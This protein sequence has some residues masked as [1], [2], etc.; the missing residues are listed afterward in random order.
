MKREDK[1]TCSNIYFSSGAYQQVVMDLVNNV[2]ENDTIKINDE[3]VSC[4]KNE[5]RFDKAKNN[6]ENLMLFDLNDDELQVTFSVHFYHTKQKIT[7]QGTRF[8][9][10]ADRFLH[11]LLESQ[12][13]E[14]EDEIKKA[15]TILQFASKN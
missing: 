8:I 4:K 9:K 11:P 14:K 3:S 6:V 13:K 7:V 10:F 12:I 1:S 2:K 15:N 5:A